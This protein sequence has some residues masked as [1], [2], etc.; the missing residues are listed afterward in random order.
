MK[1]ILVIEDNAE[2]RENTAEILSLARYGV[3]TAENGMNGIGVAFREKPDLI[4]CDINMPLLDGYGVFH[5]L[6]SNPAVRNTPFIFITGL[7][8]GTEMRKCMG[9]GA[10]D[11]ISKPFGEPE[12]LYAVG[13]GLKKYDLLKKDV[14]GEAGETYNGY[15]R[16]E[17]GQ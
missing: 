6:K 5:L 14:P 3:F 12:L 8:G 1:Q 17:S 2:M 15:I 13:R 4:I 11:F 7:A 10:D 9:L 16:P